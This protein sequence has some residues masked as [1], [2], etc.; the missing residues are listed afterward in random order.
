MLICVPFFTVI[1]LNID[2]FETTIVNEKHFDSNSDA[3]LYANEMKQA[4]YTTVV[5]QI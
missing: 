1:V 5:A 4:G 2:I 3:I